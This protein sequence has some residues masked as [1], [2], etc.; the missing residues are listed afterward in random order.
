MSAHTPTTAH[1]EVAG[2]EH[3][4]PTLLGLGAEGW[5]YTGVTIFLLLALFVGKAHKRI[6]DALDGRIAD[7]KRTLD[8]AARI[9]V[10]AEA[11]LA[12]AKKQQ[13]ASAANAKAL[14]AAAEVEAGH[15]VAKAESDAKDLIARRTRMAEDSI[16]AAE[17]SAIA[18]VR[19]R[20]AALATAAATQMIADGH[21]A[22]AD[23][24]IVD[25]TIAR[26]N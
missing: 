17:R 12:D 25:A 3:E 23:K 24:S 21:S 5:V 11:L 15:V 4:G 1:T 6:A 7:T 18:D 13:A 14:L 8:E 19:A 20:A 2:G 10:D 9:R 26:L 22:E 16:A